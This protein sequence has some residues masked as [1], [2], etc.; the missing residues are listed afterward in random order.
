MLE[1]SKQSPHSGVN[2]IQVIQLL[3]DALNLYEIGQFFLQVLCTKSNEYPGIHRLQFK[4][5]STK[6]QALQSCMHRKH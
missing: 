5:L 3:S 2:S 4:T 1:F 6:E